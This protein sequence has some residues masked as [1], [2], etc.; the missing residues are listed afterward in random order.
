MAGMPGRSRKAA[1]FTPELFRFLRQLDRNN[2][3]PWFEKN[4]PRYLEHV[5]ERLLDDNVLIE[6][7]NRLWVDDDRTA[8]E[9]FDLLRELQLGFCCVDEPRDLKSSFPPVAEVTA[10]IAAVRFRGRNAE[11]WEDK[12]ASMSDKLNWTYSEEELAEWVPRVERL[13]VV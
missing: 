8:A 7:R 6:F 12:K 2:S 13:T 11:R 9:T 1:H 10:P 3:R 5:R 4:K